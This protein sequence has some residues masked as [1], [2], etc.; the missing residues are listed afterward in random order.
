[1]NAERLLTHSAAG[2]AERENDVIIP[3]DVSM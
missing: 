1:M 3:S 2:A